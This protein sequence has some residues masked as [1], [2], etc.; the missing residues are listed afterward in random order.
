MHYREFPPVSYESISNDIV[1]Y[2]SYDSVADVL[3]ADPD[4]QKVLSFNLVNDSYN[5]LV[6]S[7]MRATKID[8]LISCINFLNI[9]FV[10]RDN[11]LLHQMIIS[12]RAFFLAFAFELNYPNIIEY[13]EKSDLCNNEKEG[14]LST[15]FDTVP[16]LRRST[17]SETA[18]FFIVSFYKLSS[19]AIGE[20]KFAKRESF[21]TNCLKTARDGSNLISTIKRQE[22][23]CMLYALS[24]YKI[25]YKKGKDDEQ[26]S[27]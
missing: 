8:E 23:E 19:I 17:F 20:T 2:R 1:F 6:Y 11:K 3:S 7:L 9:N 5:D 26:W 18:K 12:N 10:V 16:H 25:E 27:E 22:L 15:M 21:G 14:K 4:Q 24:S 13:A